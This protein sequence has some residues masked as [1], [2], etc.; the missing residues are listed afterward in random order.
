LLEQIAPFYKA[1]LES[2]ATR[3]QKEIDELD[4]SIA[5]GDNS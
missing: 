4:Y 5:A 3:L 1:V 2:L